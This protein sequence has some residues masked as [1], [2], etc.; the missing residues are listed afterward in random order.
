MPAKIF[1]IILAVLLVVRICVSRLGI[2]HLTTLTW[3]SPASLSIAAALGATS[4]LVIWV[5][6][7][8]ERP[9]WQPQ[10]SIQKLLVRPLLKLPVIICL[11]IG[12]GWLSG[13]LL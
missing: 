3:L 9:G 10:N 8:K 6:D 4:S 11:G 5:Y 7:Q 12:V 13:S 2:D 1:R